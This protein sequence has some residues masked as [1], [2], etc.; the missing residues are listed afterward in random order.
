[1]SIYKDKTFNK[2]RATYNYCNVKYR[3]PG[4]YMTKEEA[5]EKWCELDSEL[6]RAYAEGGVENRVYKF[7]TIVN[8][9]K[10]GGNVLS[11]SS[12]MSCVDMLYGFKKDYET[13]YD[14]KDGIMYET[15]LYEKLTHLTFGDDFKKNEL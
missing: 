13:R 5:D 12:E 8:R 9:N 7:F 15:Y 10:L 14:R 1:M 4:L 11:S 3:I 2:W 6:N